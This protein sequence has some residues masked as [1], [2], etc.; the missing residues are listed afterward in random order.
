MRPPG[1][2][3]CHE[4]DEQHHLRNEIFRRTPRAEI[5]P[6][7]LAELHPLAAGGRPAERD[8]RG[9]TTPGPRGPCWL[10]TE[11]HRRGRGRPRRPRARPHHSIHSGPRPRQQQQQHAQAPSATST[12]EQECCGCTLRQY[13]PAS[14]PHDARLLFVRVDV[15]NPV[16]IARG[17]VLLGPPTVAKDDWRKETCGAKR[18]RKNKLGTDIAAARAPYSRARARTKSA[19][20]T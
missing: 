10:S 4:R 14:P 8:R 12:A 5:L 3:T 20:H 9:A 6:S 19:N 16:R 18:T 11:A 13:I 1:E 17:S 2:L 7:V 15:L